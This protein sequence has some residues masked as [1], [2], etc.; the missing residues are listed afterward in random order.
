MIKFPY[1]SFLQLLEA[2]HIVQNILT[3]RWIYGAVTKILTANLLDQLTSSWIP[4]ASA[5]NAE[6]P[7][8]VDA[9][10]L[11]KI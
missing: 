6:K 8:V 10:L 3:V 7:K 5:T 2:G 9:E 11:Q 1:K 4:F